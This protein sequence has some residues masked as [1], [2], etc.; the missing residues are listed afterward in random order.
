MKKTYIYLIFAVMV[1]AQIGLSAQIV[2]EYETTITSGNVYKFKTAPVDPY[3][4]FRGKYIVLDFEM[5]FFKTDSNNWNPYEK[6]YLY[7]TKDEN[8]FAVIDT[9]SRRKLR[10][11]PNDYVEV[12]IGS[13]YSG[14][15]HFN[16]PFDK[17][18]MEESKAY[19]AEL[20]Y[21]STQRSDDLEDVYA[22]V[23]I[24]NDT[25]VLTDVV[26]DGMSIKDAV[27]K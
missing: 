1:I 25:H 26:I 20:L 16:L 15:I 14:Q 13:Y 8:D 23:H 10:D 5:D 18:Y 12:E 27:K 9:L 6:A 24:Q 4:P 22:V 2:Y 17:Y 21:R 7:L 3:D 11:N 19:D